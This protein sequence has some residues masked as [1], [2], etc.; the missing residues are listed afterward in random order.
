MLRPDQRIRGDCIEI[1]EIAL[2]KRPQ[3]EDVADK[4]GL[5][6]EPNDRAKI[7]ASQP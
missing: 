6:I 3:L 2:P 4:M 1:V 5:S 7:S